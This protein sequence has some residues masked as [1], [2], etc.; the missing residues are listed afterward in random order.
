MKLGREILAL[1][2]MGAVLPCMGAIRLCSCKSLL[3]S[4]HKSVYADFPRVAVSSYIA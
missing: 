1:D 2:F 3:L 4:R